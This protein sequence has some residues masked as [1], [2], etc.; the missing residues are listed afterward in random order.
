MQIIEETQKGGDT[1][2]LSYRLRSPDGG[3]APAW[4]TQVGPLSFIGQPGADAGMVDLSLSIVQRDGRTSDHRLQL[5][6]TNGNLFQPP[7]SEQRGFDGTL[8]PM[9]SEQMSENCKDT[10]RSRR[11]WVLYEHKRRG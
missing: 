8:A 11:P 9:F 4:L 2:V 6:T 10:T 1:S 7:A 5:D 3:A